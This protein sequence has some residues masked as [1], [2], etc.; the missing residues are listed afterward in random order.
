MAE[1]RGQSSILLRARWLL[2]VT[3]PPIQDGAVLVKGKQIAAVGKFAD[4][5]ADTASVRLE[6]PDGILLPGFVNPHTHL[7]NTCFAGAIKRTQPF[8]KW[9]L[10]MIRLVRSQSF[11]DA[12]ASA[13]S[14]IKQIVKF[15]VTCV[16][17]FSRLGAS[18][19][20]LKEEK[21]RGVV[22]KE[23][24]CLDD[25]EAERRLTELNQWIE[26]AKPQMGSLLNV[27]L[28]PHAPYT[29]TP[30]AFKRVLE[31]AEKQNLRLCTH[32]AES[33]SER[34]LIERR[35]GIWRWWLGKVLHKAPL[36]FS[37][38]RYLDWLGVLRH[39]TLLV[40]CTQVDDA[41]IAILSERKVW[42]AHCPRSNANLKVGTMPL[43]KM[44]SAGV[45]VCL[46]TDGL[47]S[48]DSLSPLDEIRFAIKLAQEHPKIYPS[49][50]PD[51]WLRMVTLD[52][53]AALGIDKFV[54]SLEQGKKA[55]IAVFRVGSQ[56]DEPFEALLF[57][58]GEAAL[59]MVDGSVISS[60]CQIT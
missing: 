49:L 22:F 39:K 16:G 43:G 59:T 23:F 2:P 25:D 6:F 8:N 60:D 10:Q 30:F 36:G 35:K 51:Q 42:V 57:G 53:A 41:D 31:L 5:S 32:A 7:E 45:K 17:E 1:E 24:I 48:V 29:V 12:F 26:G 44:L 54:G 11:E 50:P 21:L 34:Q 13:K 33:P 4:L 18:L 52:A 56:I 14:G 46:A 28:G 40:H 37:P 20:A 27:A 15:G 9:L 3:A 55:D 58:A 19:L 47:A 38:I